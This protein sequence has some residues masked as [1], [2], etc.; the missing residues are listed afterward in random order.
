MFPTTTKHLRLDL[1][2]LYFNVL[3][4]IVESISENWF[5]TVC[6]SCLWTI[7]RWIS[8]WAKLIKTDKSLEPCHIS[9]NHV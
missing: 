8:C 1:S 7:S 4:L 3:E 9:D 6:E 2:Y 5:R